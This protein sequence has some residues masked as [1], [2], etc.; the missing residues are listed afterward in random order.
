MCPSPAP[1]P[2]ASRRSSALARC[3]ALQRDQ[4]RE[5]VRDAG[6]ARSRQEPDSRVRNVGGRAPARFVCR[7]VVP[8]DE[9][10]ALRHQREQRVGE[11]PPVCAPCALLGKQL[12][13]GDQTGLAKRVAG[14]EQAPT[15][16]VDAGA[17]V[18]RHHR[19][20]HREAGRVRGR[21]RY[22]RAPQAKRRLDETCPW[23][24][25]EA[26]PERAESRGDA[27]HRA[28]RRP[29]RVVHELLAE[30]NLEPDERG[31]AGGLSEARHGDEAV[32]VHRRSLARV[33]DDRV[34]AA[35][36][37][38]HDRLCDAR[39]EAG[40]HGGVGR[41]PAL[42]ENLGARLDGGRMSGGDA[43]R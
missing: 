25:S 31:L 21:H 33:V 28:R 38:G 27:G 2:S 18:H 37:A 19:L 15:R 32:E 35:E 22:V 14:R 36:Q 20:E 29:D 6:E 16:R 4:A 34:T 43:C 24:P 11:R 40:R 3:D 39:G 5:R 42:L 30:R 23:K 41:R 9:A 1:S 17:F 8:R 7:E 12:E 13:G 10:A 26:L